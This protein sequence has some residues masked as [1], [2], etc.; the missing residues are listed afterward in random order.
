M[1]KELVGLQGKTKLLKQFF[2]LFLIL[3]VSISCKKDI[4][5]PKSDQ[6]FKVLFVGNSFTFYNQGVDYHLQKMLEADLSSSDSNN[7]VIQKIAFSSYTLED[8]FNDS[9]TIDKI[10]NEGW[11][12]VV[13]QEQ[14]TRPINNP[15][16]F[17][18]YASKL[19][20]IIKVIKSRT[21]LFMTWAPKASP[22]DIN[23][24]AASYQSVGSK[25]NAQLVPVGL[26]WNDFQKAHPEINLYFTDNKHPSL[27]GT[28]LAACVF[29]TYLF[30]KNIIIN[31]YLPTGMTSSDAIQIRTGVY[32]YFQN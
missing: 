6:Y 23:T 26:V 5:V 30:K 2:L 24:I 10:K 11:D 12:I 7:Y 27:Y 20:S 1:V 25:I 28:Y 16:L 13:L 22:G 19:D 15:D 14:S 18:E 31:D 21:A 3:G 9:R 17:L 32:N 4:E 8:H 29:Y